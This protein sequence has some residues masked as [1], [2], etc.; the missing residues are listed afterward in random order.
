L[1]ISVAT[2]RPSFA[3]PFPRRLGLGAKQV[4]IVS[5]RVPRAKAIVVRRGI[6]RV[7]FLQEAEHASGRQPGDR[8]PQAVSRVPREIEVAGRHKRAVEQHPRLHLVGIER[9]GADHEQAIAEQTGF[10]QRP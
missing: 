10:I 9:V 1:P 8:K 2:V 6:G 3:A 5:I 4:H 7:R